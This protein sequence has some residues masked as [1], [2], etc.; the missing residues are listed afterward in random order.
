MAD[1]NPMMARTIR[2]SRRVKAVW[3]MV[4][5]L[6]VDGGDGNRPRPRRRPPRNRRGGEIEDEDEEDDEDDS[7]K[8]AGVASPSTINSCSINSSM[9]LFPAQDIVFVRAAFWADGWISAGGAIRTKGPNCYR[10]RDQ[11]AGV[12]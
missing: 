3:L 10:A 5:E 12:R 6:M 4:G 8:A 1:R 7:E 11:E 2:S 9:L